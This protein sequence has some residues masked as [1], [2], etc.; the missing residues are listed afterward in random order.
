MMCE[1]VRGGAPEP[2]EPNAGLP[3][4]IQTPVHLRQPRP[5]VYELPKLAPVLPRGP[6]APTKGAPGTEACEHHAGNAAICGRC[7]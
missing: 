6:P 1:A 3:A 5:V 4:G 2:A 7:I